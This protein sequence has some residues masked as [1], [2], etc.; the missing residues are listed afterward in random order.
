LSYN[1]EVDTSNWDDWKAQIEE[2]FGAMGD[3]LQQFLENRIIPQLQS[4]AG[5][6]RRVITGKYMNDWQARSEGQGAVVETDAYY[7]VFLEYGTGDKP[8]A[9]GF[10][11]PVNPRFRARGALSEGSFMRTGQGIQPKPIVAEA[12]ANMGDD[13]T[14]F[15]AEALGLDSP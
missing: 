5:S 4:E 6:E 11:K 9:M 7:W 1:V 2:K 3:F 14:H 12:L 13:L 8:R 15:L 10:R